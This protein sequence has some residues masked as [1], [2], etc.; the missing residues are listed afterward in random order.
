MLNL[1][2]MYTMFQTK[3]EKRQYLRITR[4]QTNS[5]LIDIT[6]HH[7]FQ[8]MLVQ[9][10]MIIPIDLTNYNPSE[11]KV[12]LLI[13]TIPI[14]WMKIRKRI[15]GHTR[16]HLCQWYMKDHRE[17]NHKLLIKERGERFLRWYHL[18][19]RGLAKIAIWI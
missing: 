6:N 3:T 17:R 11:L 10:T 4:L 2:A 13:L 5:I 9:I 16:I 19:D 8:V 1:K 18:T 15:K 12:N 7:L 14:H